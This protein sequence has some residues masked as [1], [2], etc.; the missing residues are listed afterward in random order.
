MID[1]VAFIIVVFIITAG[2]VVND[3]HSR[4]HEYRMKQLEQDHD[5]ITENNDTER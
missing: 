1:G 4:N 5:L 3:Y 2:V